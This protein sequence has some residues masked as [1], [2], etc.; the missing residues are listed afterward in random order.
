LT[1]PLLPDQN[2]K[3]GI[4]KFITLYLTFI[5]ITVTVSAQNVL[6]YN[7]ENNLQ[8]ANSQGPELTILGTEGVF[9][10]DTL[11]EIGSEKKWVYRFEQNSGLQFDNASFFQESYTIEVYFVFDHLDS[12]KRVVDWKNR[13]S[14]RGAYVYWG[15]LNFY[16]FVYSD[17]APVVEGEYT[18][19]VI[20]R[21]ASTGEVLLYADGE[22]EIEFVDGSGDALVDEDNVLNFFHDDLVVANEA[23]SGAVAM[24]RLYDYALD[25]NA[26]KQNFENLG[27]N[28]FS[29]N[30]YR[31][32]IVEIRVY[33]NP[34]A[35]VATL[36]LNAFGDEPKA[37]VTV[38]NLLGQTIFT[39][40]VDLQYETTVKIDVTT[41]PEGIYLLK[42]ESPSRIATGKIIVH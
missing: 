9:V 17:E 42:T 13:K 5:F 1:L 28:V 29:V 33:P 14:D 22:N 7:F 12:W 34:V 38:Q 31:K 35:S 19:Y 39:S 30:E 36:D 4:M 25:S 37:I 27:S 8:E 3:E 11:L 2:K 16:P 24:L 41:V 26:I 20:T 32:N 6:T 40:E 21:D 10:E 15:E 18:Y 23:S